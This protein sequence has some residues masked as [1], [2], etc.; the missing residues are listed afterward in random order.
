MGDFQQDTDLYL[1]A[2]YEH[3]DYFC[4]ASILMIITYLCRLSKNEFLVRF[5]SF[6][7]DTLMLSTDI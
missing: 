5:Y 2:S 6:R 1:I 3:V 4:K 7:V